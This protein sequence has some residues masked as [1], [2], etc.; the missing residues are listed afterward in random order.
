[1]SQ[2]KRKRLRWPAYRIYDTM[3][4]AML[5]EYNCSTV[6][7]LKKAYKAKQRRKL[8]IVDTQKKA[9]RIAFW[10]G[11]LYYALMVLYSPIYFVVTVAKVILYF[12]LA[13]L[14]LLSWDWDRFKRMMYVLTHTNPFS[15]GY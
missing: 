6:A 13:I 10:M 4:P 14:A 2:P 15:H 3:V 5:T 11:I 12:V 7:E 1:M 9:E 8:I